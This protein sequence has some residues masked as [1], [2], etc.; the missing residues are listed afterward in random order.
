MEVFATVVMLA[1]IPAVLALF[2]V[3][4]PRRAV[5]VAFLGAWLFLPMVSYRLPFLPDYTKMSATCAG[6]FLGA[7]VFDGRRL[8]SF[9]PRWIDL[10]VAIYCMSAIATSMLNG[11]GLY[12]GISGLLTG[13]VTWAMPY[14]IGRV[15]FTDAEG[16]RELA[17]SIFIGGLLYIPLCLFEI[18]MSPQLHQMVYGF[19]PRQV[20]MRMGGWRPSVFM[21]GGLQLGLWMACAS[22]SG[23]W[24][25]WT[26]AVKRLVGVSMTW[27][28]WPL[29]VTTILCR[30]TGAVVLMMGMLGALWFC[31][32]SRTRLAL[33]VLILAAPAYI[34]LRTSGLWHADEIVAISAKF[35]KD[36]AA[37][38]AFRIKNEDFLIAK[39][40]VQ[41][42]F[43][44][45][46]WGR[47]RIYDEYE[48][49]ISITDGR[50]VIELGVHGL[51]GVISNFAMLLLPVCLLAYRYP[52]ARLFSAELAPV[53]AL[54]SMVIMFAIDSL[55]NSMANPIYVL[56]GGAV[57]TFALAKPRALEETTGKASN[58]AP[59]Q[60]VAKSVPLRRLHPG[61]A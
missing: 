44:W 5:I 13:I 60:G 61:S 37:S 12:D 42:V 40:M 46:G 31:R 50:W 53:A 2:A 25:W 52:A 54:A 23:L 19:A 27:F 6:I 34:G 29:L 26:G 17:I 24:L 18:R 32:V 41:P 3:L 49:D 59:R 35:N 56:A 47:S 38:F 28:V 7:L 51:V 9:K 14:F 55:P 1:W 43:G 33:I 57:A 48:H 22:L 15:Y 4:P 30:A 58:E 39:A 21:D 16:L 36:R 45:G 8:L 11:L 10:P 20:Q